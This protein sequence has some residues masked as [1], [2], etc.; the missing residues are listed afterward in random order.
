MRSLGEIQRRLWRWITAPEGVAA[1]LA[2]QGDPQAHELVR[3]IRGDARL[4]AVE[5]LEV[6]ANAYFYRILECMRG[7]FPGLERTLGSE[8][9]HD[10]VTSYLAVR[11]SEHFSI[12]WVGEGLAGFLDDHDA[13][14]WFREHHPWAADLARLEWALGEV[15]DSRDSPTARTE[16]YAQVVP[17]AWAEMSLQLVPAVRLLALDWPVHELR[18]A[19]TSEP[20]EELLR[21]GASEGLRLPDPARSSEPAADRA[22]SRRATHLCVWRREERVFQRVLEPLEAAAL[23]RTR[24]GV[25]FGELCELAAQHLGDA[26]APAHA[27]G[28]LATWTQ[29][30][31][32][33]R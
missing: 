32:L 29:A 24:Q 31:L 16:Q 4:G 30:Q 21:G 10:L 18:R 13:A 20:A 17:D 7:E 11:P 22:L 3:V 12:R 1:E 26:E 5:R 27:A 9:F 33:Q 19:G 8:L 14:S 25:R 2:G 15:F 28:W 6:Y 23:E